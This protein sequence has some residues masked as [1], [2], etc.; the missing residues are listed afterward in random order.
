MKRPQPCAPQTLDGDGAFSPDD[1]EARE[2]LEKTIDALTQVL[3]LL[4]EL[5]RRAAEGEQ[6][7]TSSVAS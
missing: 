4:R 7:G 2:R 3:S 1:L 5:K 6:E